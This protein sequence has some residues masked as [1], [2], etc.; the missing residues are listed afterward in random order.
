MAFDGTGGNCWDPDWPYSGDY[1][2]RMRT[3]KFGDGYEQRIVDGLNPLMTTWKL[4]W[5]MRPR[6]VLIDMNIFLAT[7]YGAAFPW[8]PLRAITPVLV[9]CDTWTA[10][11]VYKG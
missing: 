4:T 7:R 2:T 3:A 8:L 6:Q 5:S 1:E 9:F 11:W 10:Q